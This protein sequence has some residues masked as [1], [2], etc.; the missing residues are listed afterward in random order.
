[1]DRSLHLHDRDH[2]RPFDAQSLNAVRTNAKSPGTAEC[3][4]LRHLLR[5]DGTPYTPIKLKRYSSPT[6]YGMPKRPI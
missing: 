5:K 2:C 4:I 6:S 1:L 3:T